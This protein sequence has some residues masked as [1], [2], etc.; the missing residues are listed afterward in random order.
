MLAIRFLLSGFAVWFAAFAF[1]TMLI[2]EHVI[3]V[4]SLVI[5]LALVVIGSIVSWLTLRRGTRKHAQSE[6]CARCNR[7]KSDPYFQR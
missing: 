1:F 6:Y 7:L 3:A 5:S 4:A 2:N